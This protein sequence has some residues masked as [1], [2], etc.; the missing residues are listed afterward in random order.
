MSQSG[1]AHVARAKDCMAIWPYFFS[2]LNRRSVKSQRNKKKKNWVQTPVNRNYET[3]IH[4]MCRGLSWQ[5]E[6]ASGSG[7]ELWL[8]TL[9]CLVCGQT[10]PATF[11]CDL[12][13]PRYP[14]N[15]TDSKPF[16]IAYAC[17]CLI[18]FCLCCVLCVCVCVEQKRYIKPFATPF[19]P[20]HLFA[21]EH[22]PSIFSHTH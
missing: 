19:F 2:P 9:H 14:T 20:V 15:Q 11:V 13:M 6:S 12:R 1:I 16:I 10:S 4:T 8:V 22:L 5:R 7:V 17:L 18:F 21:A 3:S